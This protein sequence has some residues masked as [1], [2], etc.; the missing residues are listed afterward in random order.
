M[1]GL[2]Q[3][4]MKNIK[5]F[6]VILVLIAIFVAYKC[7]TKYTAAQEAKKMAAA[8]K[9]KEKNESSEYYRYGLELSE[10]ARLQFDKPSV[11]TGLY[12]TPLSRV[13]FGTYGVTS[14]DPLENIIYGD[15]KSFGG[16]AQE[17]QRRSKAKDLSEF[18]AYGGEDTSML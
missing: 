9:Q 10:I 5:I 2:K 11:T 17:K 12:D 6:T 7:Y 4:Y 3:F 18:T 14:E 1:S 16:S 13:D 15:I 8:L